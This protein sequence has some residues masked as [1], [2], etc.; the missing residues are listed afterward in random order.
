MKQRYGARFFAF[1]DDN[2]SLDA[3]RCRELCRA[4]AREE[5]RFYCE[6]STTVARQNGLIEELARAGCVS[7]LLGMES[8]DEQNL[9]SVR[10]GFNKPSEYRELFSRFRR[11]RISAM[12]AMIFG[13]DHDDREVFLRT[14]SFLKQ[15]NVPRALL[16]LLTPVPG[17]VLYEQLKQSDRIWDENLSHYDGAHAVFKPARM[18]PH[19]LEEGLWTAYRTFYD[20]PSII[21]RTIKAGRRAALY[22]LVSNWRFR[23][24]VYQRLYPYNSGVD[25]IS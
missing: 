2:F 6:L 23:E 4:L 8:I 21:L 9:A 5:I 1:A 10:K 24:L 19:E 12:A 22:T 11:H 3:D 25:R 15:C 14:V 20:F 7:A 17:T 13:F 18:S 16:T